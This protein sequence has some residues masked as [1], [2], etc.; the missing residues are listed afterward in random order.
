MNLQHVR[1][2]KINFEIL[3]E[4]QCEKHPNEKQLEDVQNCIFNGAPLCLKCA[5]EMSLINYY[6][7]I[8]ND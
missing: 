8:E 1:G 6:K 2:K 7:K 3:A 5:E 4:F